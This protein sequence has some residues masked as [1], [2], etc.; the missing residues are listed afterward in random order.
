MHFKPFN[1]NNEYYTIRNDIS[2]AICIDNFY[3]WTLFSKLI[4]SIVN[5][6]NVIL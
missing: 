1:N 5:V 3:D 4:I 2:D 6:D